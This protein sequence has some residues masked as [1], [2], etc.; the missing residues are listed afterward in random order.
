MRVSVLTSC[1]LCDVLFHLSDVAGSYSPPIRSARMPTGRA[2]SVPSVCE[3]PGLCLCIL[4]LEGTC[5]RN[6]ALVSAH[7]AA[8]LLARPKKAKLGASL[9]SEKLSALFPGELTVG[10]NSRDVRVFGI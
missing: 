3:R 8:G 6:R 4:P 10:R 1:C 7:R 5:T 9:L 2:E